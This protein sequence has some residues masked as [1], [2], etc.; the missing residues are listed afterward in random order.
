MTAFGSASEGVTRLNQRWEVDSTVLDALLKGETRRRCLLQVVDVYS[1]RRLFM[2]A[3]TS[4]A[5]AIGRLLL[6]AIREWGLPEE[7]KTDNGKDYVGRLL[8]EFFK[9]LGIRHTRCQFRR[10]DQKPHVENGFLGIRKAFISK[11]PGYVGHNVAEAQEIRAR[12]GPGEGLTLEEFNARLDVWMDRD[13]H[14]KRSKAGRLKGKSPADMVAAWVAVKGN[15]VRRVRDADLLGYLLSVPEP[16]TVGKKGIRYDNRWFISGEMVVGRAVSVRE[17]P[18]DAGRLAVF[19]QGEGGRFLYMAFDPAM[20]GI[21]QAEMAAIA[22]NRQKA[23]V[24]AAK[25]FQREAKKFARAV[26][27]AQEAIDARQTSNVRR[28]ERPAFVEGTDALAAALAANAAERLA[29]KAAQRGTGAPAGARRGPGAPAEWEAM[30]A[31]GALLAPAA[32]AG[33]DE[34]E[35]FIRLMG[36]GSI[37][38]AEDR[39]FAAFYADTDTGRG[40]LAALNPRIGPDGRERGTA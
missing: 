26:S 35:R 15:E 11:L 37:G 9:A 28:L 1:G 7:V 38:N 32:P 4:N 24:A 2:L 20:E 40:I 25:E 10:G 13:Y 34:E 36:R 6:R 39:E 21:D 5:K 14:Q 3:L 27:G 31:E 12:G 29:A 23:A 22:R 30:E 8:A 18:D 19:E 16:R 33:E 17:S